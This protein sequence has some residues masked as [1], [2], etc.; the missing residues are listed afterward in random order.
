[1]LQLIADENARLD[2]IVR[3]VEADPTIAGRLLKLV[4]SP[5]AGVSRTV[6][7]VD[8]AVK[9]LGLQTIRG[10]ALGYS[11]MSTSRTGACDSFPYE[12]FWSESL[13]RAAAAR[14]LAAQTK[15]VSADEAFTVGLV[16]KIGRLA[17]ATAF[18][19]EYSRILFSVADRNVDAL[20]QAE[21]TAFEIDHNELSADMLQDWHLPELFSQSVR[22]QDRREPSSPP[23]GSRVDDMACLLRMA[24]VLAEVLVEPN[25]HSEDAARIRET[26]RQLGIASDVVCS[27]YDVARNEWQALGQVYSVKTH[28]SPS[29]RELGTRAPRENH[30]VLIADHDAS[31]LRH[32]AEQLTSAGYEVLTAT[33]GAEAL[34]VLRAEDV[35]LLI[36]DSVMPDMDGLRICR[37]LRETEEVGF[38]Y[39][40]LLTAD[41][42]S[43]SL[44]DAFEAGA[45]DYIHRP[46]EPQELLARLKA[47]ARM[48]DLE[49]RLAAHKL[50]AVRA[51]AEF[52]VL[53][54]KLEHAAT[55]DELTGLGNRRLAMERLGEAWA[56]SVRTGKPL[57]CMAIDIDHFKKINDTY[58]HQAGD[59]VLRE[60]AAMLRQAARAG[61]PLFR[62]GGE[63]FL[64]LCPDAMEDAAALG[65]ERLR[66]A[67]AAN[68]VTYG[69][70]RVSA[71]ISVGVARRD[72]TLSD[73]GGLV[74]RADEALYGAKRNG[75]NRVC[76]W[77]AQVERTVETDH[78][79]VQAKTSG[80]KPVMGPFKLLV[81]DDD[82]DCRRLWRYHLTKSGHAVVEAESGEAALGVVLSACPDVVVMDVNMP[83]MGGLECTRRLKAHP[84][85]CH[86]P[87]L[88]ASAKAGSEEVVEGLKAGANEYVTKM[89]HPSEFVTRIE[90]LG[91]SYR[92]SLQIREGAA[93]L[94]V[95]NAQRGEQARAMVIL[96]ELASALN[97]C[98]LEEEILA[99]LV[100]AA[101]NLLVCQRVSIMFPNHAGD[102]LTI[103]KSVGMDDET[104]ALVRVKPGQP[105]SGRVFATGEAQ[106][107]NSP[108]D[109][110]AA[111]NR[112]D[113][114][115]FA[116]VPLASVALGADDV[117]IGVLNVTERVERRPFGEREIEYLNV[118]ASLAFSSLRQHRNQ[119]AKEDAQL[120]VVTGLAT[121]AENRDVN[122]GRH[123]ERVTTYAGMLAEELH[124]RG[125]YTREIDAEFI[126][127]LKA[128]MPLHD[129]GKVGVPDAILF[130]PGSLTE[131]ERRIMERHTSIGAKAIQAVMERAPSANFLT[132]ARQIALHHH[133]RFDG[134]GYPIGL[135]G[136]RIPL[137]A[138]IA[139]VADVYDA[140]RTERSYKDAMSH[141]KA[142]GI[143][144]QGQGTQ[145][146]PHVVDAFLR[147]QTRI[148]ACAMKSDREPATAP[149]AVIPDQILVPAAG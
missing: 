24:G 67:V 130:K 144:R 3:T 139:S 119:K 63:E 69:A 50:A 45:D 35:R 11:L 126:E 140:L 148:E 96:F 8:T 86:I 95:A 81:V 61:E 44:L 85:A 15:I 78:G 59:L 107:A 14:T 70:E 71:T 1:M 58:G 103:A 33:N 68:T 36:T 83:G 76:V 117:V 27:A 147:C 113:S 49:S 40:I 55:T 125:P 133:E 127:D 97:E 17:L 16:G 100:D 38:V 98:S 143:I 74:R 51:N 115:F 137:V 60:T 124:K 131:A 102:E 57:A 46:Y 6:A 141:E 28:E 88:V 136:E 31:S 129:I 101:S 132:L 21:L 123:L 134:R 64:L 20:L 87:V 105:V 25:T 73:A 48:V 62:I 7:S 26:A 53:N 22:L 94:V 77:G 122:T 120:A 52:A 29:L 121:L 19:H 116:S 79:D 66:R 99:L 118:L 56:T 109:F 12:R 72:G 112:Y 4:N 92:K 104:A 10:L 146:D 114:H 93:E 149:Q 41:T 108:A 128:A 106:I 142:V 23:Q 34:R 5:F 13:A 32:L 37:A 30:R 110:F 47:G 89:V 138:R 9:M 54:E 80:G 111:E 82:P 43:N 91:C 90:A 84:V 65:A 145:F 135:A 75:R 18:P 39:I 42:D 2:E